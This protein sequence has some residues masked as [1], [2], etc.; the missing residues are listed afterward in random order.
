MPTTTIDSTALL[1]ILNVGM[2]PARNQIA[3][4]VS[5]LLPDDRR[6][7]S[8]C[9]TLTFERTLR[10]FSRRVDFTGEP[11]IEKL[12][13][14][15]A[16]DIS[17][18]AETLSDV[19]REPEDQVVVDSILPDAIRT[20]SDDLA[21]AAQRAEAQPDPIELGNELLTQ[22]VLEKPQQC[23]EATC[24]RRTSSSLSDLA[25][26]SWFGRDRRDLAS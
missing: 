13:A 15:E 8:P 5:M 3:A 2:R 21:A 26:R 17:K 19:L 18:V 14:A 10:R 12:S 6:D 16:H 9:P 23:I 1:S 25:G 24:S 22:D 11:P 4:I 20:L 7:S